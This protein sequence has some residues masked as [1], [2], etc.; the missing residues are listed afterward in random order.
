MCRRM[1]HILVHKRQIGEPKNEARK[2]VVYGEI[3]EKS[4]EFGDFESNPAHNRREF[5]AHFGTEIGRKSGEKTTLLGDKFL[6][7]VV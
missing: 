7:V 2:V 1:R 3:T 4:T 6:S 5:C